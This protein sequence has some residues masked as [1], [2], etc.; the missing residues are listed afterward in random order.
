M[1]PTD[2]PPSAG[3]ESD[4]GP[5]TDREVQVLALVAQGLTDKG[6]AHEMGISKHTVAFHLRNTR[7]KLDAASRVEAVT[8][9]RQAG[10]DV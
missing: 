6:I 3:S 2:F 4:P 8:R 5:L 10:Y 1:A 9:A 7:R